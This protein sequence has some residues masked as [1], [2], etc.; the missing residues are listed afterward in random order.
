VLDGTGEEVL[1][2][3]EGGADWHHSDQLERVMDR[4]RMMNPFYRLRPVLGIALLSTRNPIRELQYALEEERS[5]VDFG[6]WIQLFLVDGFEGEKEKRV[7]WRG[8]LVSTSP[9]YMSIRIRRLAWNAH[10]SKLQQ[11]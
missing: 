9:T 6:V 8:V 3:G 1:K 2:T 10:P 5:P 7:R 4:C 11:A